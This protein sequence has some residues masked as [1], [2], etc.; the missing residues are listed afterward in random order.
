M[1][2]AYKGADVANS[3]FDP[4]IRSRLYLS[5][6]VVTASFFILL[7]VLVSIYPALKIRNLNPIDVMTK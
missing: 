5:D 4:I 6:F 2:A 1:G 3:L 7:S